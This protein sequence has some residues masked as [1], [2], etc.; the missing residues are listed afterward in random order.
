MLSTVASSLS[1]S[2]CTCCGADVVS[3][4]VY[5]F[6]VQDSFC[7]LDVTRNAKLCALPQSADR[8]RDYSVWRWQRREATRRMLGCGA[9]FVP[10]KRDG[11]VFFQSTLLSAN[12]LSH[13]TY[14]FS[15]PP[16]G[17]AQTGGLTKEF[18]L[19]LRQLCFS[20]S[21]VESTMTPTRIR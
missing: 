1:V 3:G 7:R 20:Y 10:A 9:F 16:I 15:K 11:T 13:K 6:V 5:S 4:S 14:D 19:R 18:G 2:E 12:I 8:R 21:I 17:A